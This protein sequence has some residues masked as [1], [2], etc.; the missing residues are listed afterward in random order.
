MK[1]SVSVLFHFLALAL[2]L[3]AGLFSCKKHD[4][5]TQ[6]T[7]T[8]T[9]QT[10]RR[11]SFDLYNSEEDYYHNANRMEQYNIEAG[12][13]QKM[14]LDVARVYWVDWYSADYRYNNW[15]SAFN[16]VDPG[17]K[18]QI[19]MVD[20]VR[21]IKASSPDTLRSV[22]LNGSG[23]SSTWKGTITTSS[24]IKGDHQF[25]FAKDFTGKYTFTDPIGGSYVRD[26]KYSFSS[27]SQQGTS[28]YRFT[29]ALRDE[30]DVNFFSVACNLF[31]YTPHTGRDS[32]WVS[33]QSGSFSDQFFIVRQ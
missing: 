27:F 3:V 21:N 23:T 16:S 11:I 33:P 24:P 26:F 22:M 32:L 15:A 1:K 12:A 31:N 10:G 30:S 29:L 9:N 20:D 28:M 17:P 5:P 2:C 7:Y 25:V 19:A 4:I 14:V 13:S 18:L 8:F 6:S